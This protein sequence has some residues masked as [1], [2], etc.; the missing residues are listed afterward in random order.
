MDIGQLLPDGR[1]S[2]M[3]IATDTATGGSNGSFNQEKLRTAAA[4]SSKTSKTVY[5]FVICNR[6]FTRLVR[7]R[8]FNWP[9]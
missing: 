2:R 9:P 8:S 4:S 1:P 3:E 5:S 6:S 7:L